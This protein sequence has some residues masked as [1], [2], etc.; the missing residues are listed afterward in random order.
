M[1]IPF[2]FYQTQSPDIFGGGVGWGR[3]CERGFFIKSNVY[4]A[5]ELAQMPYT[6]EF[7][8]TK[9]RLFKNT[10]NFT[11]KKLKIFR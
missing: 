8:I 6:F 4:A 3:G 11:N 5:F 1:Q 7:I 2:G 9:T 10:E